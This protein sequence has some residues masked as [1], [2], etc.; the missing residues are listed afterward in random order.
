MKDEVFVPV[1]AVKGFGD[2]GHGFVAGA[3]GLIDGDLEVDGVAVVLR[4]AEGSEMS[5]VDRIGS[6]GE[7]KPDAEVVAP[8][9][10]VQSRVGL[11]DGRGAE[12][13]IDICIGIAEALA[14]DEGAEVHGLADVVVEGIEKGARDVYGEV[15]LPARRQPRG[16]AEGV[17]AAARDRQGE[18]HANGLF[19]IGGDVAGQQ[20]VVFKSPK[21]DVDDRRQILDAGETPLLVLQIGQ[22]RKAGARLGVVHPVAAFHGHAPQRV[23][24]TEEVRASGRRAPSG[25]SQIDG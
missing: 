12:V 25:N 13:V 20:P 7:G 24:S 1:G 3:G 17:V 16:Q 8:V 14:C 5:I 10:A 22:S 6:C 19:A 21:A 18:V 23:G 2:E 15:H 11:I 4:V 9:G